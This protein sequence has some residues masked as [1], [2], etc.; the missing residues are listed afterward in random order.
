MLEERVRRLILE[1]RQVI[2]VGD[3]NVCAAP[4]DHVEGTLGNNATEFWDHP[5]RAWFKK[6]IG[7]EGPMV[8]VVRMKWPDR[9][10]M[11]TCELISKFSMTEG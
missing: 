9:K 8:D 11:F 6:W 1:G 5:A 10:G 7:P 4:I 3:I 2:V